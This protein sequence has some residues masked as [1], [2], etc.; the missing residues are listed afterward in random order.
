MDISKKDSDDYVLLPERSNI[1]IMD[2][3]SKSFTYYRK[4]ANIEKEISLKK[5]R[6]YLSWVCYGC[7]NKALSSH[8]TNGVLKEFYLD[9]NFVILKR[10]YKN[11]DI[12]I[13]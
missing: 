9:L 10:Q 1:L 8:S 11:Q 3:L 12:W 2:S 7:R 6:T 13:I 4:S 5:F